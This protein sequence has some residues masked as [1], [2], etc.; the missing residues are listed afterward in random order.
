MASTSDSHVTGSLI[1]SRVSDAVRLC[2]RRN[3]AQFLGFLDQA[4][5]RLVCH[6]LSRCNGVQWLFYGGYEDAERRLL[7]VF[8]SCLEPVAEAYPLCTVAFHYRSERTLT[9]RDVLGTLMSLGLRRDCI[10]DILC[11]E[12]VSVIFLKDDITD[13]V[14]DQVNKIGGEGV[15]VE[16]DY[17]GPFP[18]A[19]SF[20]S[21][22]DT[23]ASPRLDATVKALLRCSREQAATLIQNE[24]V[25][26]DHL[27]VSSVSSQVKN[28]AII[29][30]RGYGRYVIDQIGPETKKG[31]LHFEA[32]KYV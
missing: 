21:I 22:Y 19:H 9:H 4:E 10:G 17:A 11:G 18:S 6:N 20:Q 3:M 14:C 16:R 31:R 2:E 8:P 28:G 30:V 26:I 24:A 27:P 13:F 29:S 12:G 25:S 32:R 23:I 1:L 15:R 5:Q 7:G